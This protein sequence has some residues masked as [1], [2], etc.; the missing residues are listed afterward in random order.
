MTKESLKPFEGSLHPRSDWKGENLPPDRV[1]VEAKPE[2][3]KEEVKEP[4]K[5][6][7]KK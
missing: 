6:T 3:K 2:P 1:K 4:K 7:K 5:V